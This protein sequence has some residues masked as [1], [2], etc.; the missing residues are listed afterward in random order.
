MPPGICG[1]VGP[2]RDGFSVPDGTKAKTGV[3]QKRRHANERTV[4]TFL[5]LYG[6]SAL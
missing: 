4:Y 6:G 5:L 3:M 2:V 1:G